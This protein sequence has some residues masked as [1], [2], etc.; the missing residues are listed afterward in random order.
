MT[1]T[2]LMSRLPFEMV[3]KILSF[4]E[5]SDILNF[6]KT[7]KEWQKLAVEIYFRPSLF[8]LTGYIGP[9]DG[10]DAETVLTKFKATKGRVLI[11]SQDKCN[12]V[13][14]DLLD[15]KFK[16]NIT[17]GV[18]KRFLR[19][20]YFWLNGFLLGGKILLHGENDF[21]NSEYICVLGQSELIL[22]FP[23]TERGGA[24]RVCKVD[25]STLVRL[26]GSIG[27]L[28]TFLAIDIIHF[29]PTNAANPFNVEK[30]PDFPHEI[31]GHAI[32]KSP[33]GKLY[34]IGGCYDT[35]DDI[36]VETNKTWIIDPDNGYSIIEGPKLKSARSYHSVGIIESG[37]KY[38]HIIVVGGVSPNN[39][40]PDHECCDFHEDEGNTKFKKS[41]EY[42]DPISNEWKCINKDLEQPIRDGAMIS[43]PCQ[44]SVFLIGGQI[45][46]E[47]IGED[48]SSKEIF[49]LRKWTYNAPPESDQY[50]SW[51]PL[52]HDLSCGVKFVVQ[53]PY[54]FSLSTIEQNGKEST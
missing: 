28:G 15:S 3:N 24:S 14:I 4:L 21:T 40:N 54:D 11:F 41:S 37:G 1:S 35:E 23:R 13:V 12:A 32:I 38:P 34:V 22:H 43:S 2:T 31:Y 25:D 50:M 39:N 33:G 20:E 5:I 29:D 7:C 16:Q 36:Y 52:K 45:R 19:K 49:E 8:K 42:L 9:E 48:Y 47:L 44:N 51:S 30:G 18:K 6:A 53:I 26:G 17:L 10:S 27:V 46:K